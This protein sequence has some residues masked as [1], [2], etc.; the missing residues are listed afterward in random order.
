MIAALA[1]VYVSA[2][3]LS[4]VKLLSASV[5]IPYLEYTDLHYLIVLVPLPVNTGVALSPL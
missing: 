1:A 4:K 2:N 3:A 5:L